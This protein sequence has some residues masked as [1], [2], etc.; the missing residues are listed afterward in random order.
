MFFLE[1]MLYLSRIRE[2]DGFPMKKYIILFFLV[3]IVFSAYG[4]NLSVTYID[5]FL[6]VKDGN[7]WIE[8]YIGDSLSPTDILRL[9]EDS[10]AEFSHGN[11]TIVLSSPGVYTIG[12]LIDISNNQSGI[13]NLVSRKVQQM[14]SRPGPGKSAVMGVRADKTD[15]EELSWMGS[16][17]E[18]LINW[19]R[20]KLDEGNYSEARANFLEA[21]DF[22]L[23]DF[24]KDEALF[25]LGYTELLSKNSLKA[26]ELFRDV[27]PHP[28]VIYYNQAYLLKASLLFE[29]FAWNDTIDW[30]DTFNGSDI[31]TLGSLT[32]LKGI[33]YLQLG[34]HR[35][36]DNLFEEII[37]LDPD[38]ETT[39]IAKE[40]LRKR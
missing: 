17:T 8:V 30:I 16:N 33:C 21:L 12:N 32:L 24:E 2:K 40:L 38:P 37:A 4:Q 39:E 7:S 29:S 22:A 1:K 18:E 34:S 26:L 20:E 23:D 19:G 28:S 35:E 6:E 31:E 3:I 27:S 14:F 11:Q 5:G 13:V 9:D 36:A 10:L 15:D 25:Y